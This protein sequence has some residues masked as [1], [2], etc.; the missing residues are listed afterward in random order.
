MAAK[1][2]L[3]ERVIRAATSRAERPPAAPP[4]A[5]R[6]L[7][8][9]A[10]DSLANEP[11]DETPQ[12][13]TLPAPHAV[14]D[15]VSPT[16]G[17]RPRLALLALSGGGARGAFGAGLIA[18]WTRSGTRPRF[19]AVTGISTGALIGMYAF[20]GPRYD[21]ELERL[22]TQTTDADI[23]ADRGIS[24]LIRDAVM[25]STPLKR[26]I[27]R[28]VDEKFLDAIAVEH[29]QGRRFLVGT[30][31]LD[32][33]RL[34][35]WDMGAIAA[36]DRPDRLQRF[37]DVLLA[38]A[39]VPMVFPPVYFPVEWKGETYW[40]M[41]VDGGAAVIVFMSGFVIDELSRMTGLRT[42]RGDAVVDCY[43]VLNDV[44]GDRVPEEPVE[45]TLLG[46]AGGVV[47][48]LS[49]AATVTQLLR[50]YR[51]TRGTGF[52]FHFACIPADYPH[53][54]P[55]IRFEPEKMRELSIIPGARRRRYPWAEHPPRIDPH[56]IVPHVPAPAASPPQPP[57]SG[58]AQALGRLG[59]WWRRQ[60]GPG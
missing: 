37:R 27:E 38:S 46:I 19:A 33:A 40:Q 7:P 23:Y 50:L 22:Y 26:L 6:V 59:E 41:H 2:T 42:E 56:E 18:G 25:D 44:L 32:S 16:P 34:V 57:K 43:F 28:S 55:A 58:F 47:R 20:L 1:T 5:Y 15:G 17:G 52:G 24:A 8:W 31:N 12:P 39:S 51:A 13:P 49:T 21:G 54:L 10:I 30:T 36:S 60:S 9:G 14:F 48:S 35:M 3:L 4:E 45:P 11:Q 53:R 29:R